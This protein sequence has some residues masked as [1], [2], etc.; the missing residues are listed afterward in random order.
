MY[1]TRHSVPILTSASS[2]ATVYSPICN[3]RLLSI[4]L[5]TGHTM[6]STGT[7]AITNENT[8]ETLFSLAMGSGFRKYPRPAVVNSTGGAALASTAGT[9]FRDTFFLA[10]ERIKAVVAH[11][12]AAKV[13]TLLIAI[14]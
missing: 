12:G 1:V 8:G 5:S 7:I 14:G 2:A 4:Q 9:S 13:G 10:D 3:G 6:S 11:G